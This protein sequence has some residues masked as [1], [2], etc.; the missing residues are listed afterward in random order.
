MKETPPPNSTN[1]PL[2]ATLRER[3]LYKIK[4]ELGEVGSQFLEHIFQKI[5]PIIKYWSYEIEEIPEINLDDFADITKKLKPI[6]LEFLQTVVSKLNHEQKILHAKINESY[7]DD[8]LKKVY[9]GLYT[10]YTPTATEAE[11]SLKLVMLPGAVTLIV[12]DKELMAKM[13]PDSTTNKGF[14][15]RPNYNN[16]DNWLNGRLTVVNATEGEVEETLQHEYLHFLTAMYFEKHELTPY[17]E[18]EIQEKIEEKMILEEAIAMQVTSPDRDSKVLD[19]L[20]RRKQSL[21]IDLVRETDNSDHYHKEAAITFFRKVRNE[22]SA[23]S[24]SEEIQDNE[25]KLL[26][27]KDNWLSEIEKIGHLPDKEKV[28]DGWRNLRQ[29]LATCKQE[30]VPPKKLLP[31]FITS[32]NFTEMSK[33]ISLLLN[34]KSD[35]ANEPS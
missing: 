18:T 16:T 4:D 23:Y 35:S 17:T 6:Q 11:T 25:S 7:H 26:P 3:A 29:L 28:V 32:Q 2:E 1:N 13:F 8:V 27:K 12:E 33:R 22:L 30:G 21:L 9:T 5:R 19:S 31:I 24:L 20:R 15:Y 34:P 10:K 14:Y